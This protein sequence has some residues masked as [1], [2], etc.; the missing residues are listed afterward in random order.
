MSGEIRGRIL[1]LA[2]SKWVG[3]IRI[4]APC[5]LARSQWPFASSIRTITE[6]VTSPPRRHPV[7]AYVADDHC[8]F[9]DA[10]LRAVVFADP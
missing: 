7:V 1:A 9:T 8:A 5:A 6:C 2:V 3:S 4:L 10:E